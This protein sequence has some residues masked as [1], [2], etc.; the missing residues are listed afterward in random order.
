LKSI[1]ENE[2]KNVIFNYSSLWQ[3]LDEK[4]YQPKLQLVSEH[5]DEIIGIE[6][7]YGKANKP[8]DYIDG[9]KAFIQE[10]RNKILALNVICTKP[11]E[12]DRKSLKELKLLLDH[13]GYNTMTLNTA[14]KNAKNEDIAAD[15]ISFIRT[16]ALDTDLVSHEHRIENAINK[17]K[18]L[19][20]WN[21]IQQKWLSKFQDQLLAETVLTKEDLDKAPFSNEGGFTRLNKIFDNELENILVVLNDNLY[22]A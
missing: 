17:I 15:I 19:K 6:R 4:I 8:E 16:L 3:F 14:W 10:N 7:G 21:K 20:P 12:L 22:T 18:M 2:V 9:F 13:E 5:H 11:A 1:D